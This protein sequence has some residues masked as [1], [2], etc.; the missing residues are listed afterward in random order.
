MALRTGEYSG[1][2]WT[3]ERHMMDSCKVLTR[4]AVDDG[5]NNPTETFTAGTQVACGYNPMSSKEIH[6]NGQLV[7]VDAELRISVDVQ[8]DSLDRI[9]ITKR[10]GTS[11][12]SPE[13][14]RV[15]GQPK[16][17]PSGQVVMLKRVVDE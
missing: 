17:G 16:L 2:E 12:A 7:I 13:T 10:H 1:L 8:V 9:Q 15:I 4:T 5:Y 14:F 3:Q 6:E 11:L